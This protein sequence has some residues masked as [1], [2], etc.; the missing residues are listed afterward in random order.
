MT[1]I[2]PV[3]VAI[4]VGTAIA[5]ATAVTAVVA[6]AYQGSA[7][8]RSAS[9]AGDAG[10]VGQAAAP[11]RGR[12]IV[13]LADESHRAADAPGAQV[14]SEVASDARA[15][16]SEHGASVA[17]T[18]A[19][20][21]HGFVAQAS[22][23]EAQAMSRDPRVAHVE[24]DGIVQI[25]DTQS[26]PPWGLDRID[27]ANLPLDASYTYDATGAGIHAY[28]IDTGV[29]VSHADFAGRA[30]HGFDAVDGDADASDCNGHGTHVAG[31]VGGET[32]GV[33]KDVNLVAVRV[34]DCAGRGSTSGVIAG[35]DWVTA[36]AVHP[37]TANMSLGGGVSSALDAAVANSIASGVSYAIAA[38]NGDAAGNPVDACAGSPSR[39]PEAITVSATDSSDVRAPWANTGSC[40]DVFAP[41][42]GITSAWFDS[43]TATNTISGTSMATPHTAGVAALYLETAPGAPPAD[44]ASAVA[45]N[46]TSGVVQDPGSGSPNALLNMQFT[47]AG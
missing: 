21:M 20:A 3:A 30:S 19:A 25:S 6:P 15:V 34:L 24:E 46:A 39:V 33:A 47:G 29:R 40:V 38:G 22:D 26:D 44:V 17:H 4:A 16:A 36:N 32:H 8:E 27:Q 14:A 7:S 31:T 23:A 42:V 35:V 11:L 45:G 18:Y 41:G 28:I 9:Q 1:R 10:A 43:D 5:A 12:Y 13:T 37:A 2:R